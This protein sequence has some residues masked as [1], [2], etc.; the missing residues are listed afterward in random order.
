MKL[1]F[2]LLLLASCAKEPTQQQQCVTI[3]STGTLY[4]DNWEIIEQWQIKQDKT[5][6]IEDI[7]RFKDIIAKQPSRGY[8]LC[9]PEKR[10]ET[11]S[12][13]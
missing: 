4:N 13:K 11:W 12:I 3:T 9:P 1:L 5:C 8:W 6:D 7:N 2:A 10:F